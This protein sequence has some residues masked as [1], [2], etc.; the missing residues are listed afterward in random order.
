VRIF[1]LGATGSTPLCR[2]ANNE[3][4]TC[5]SFPLAESNNGAL[6]EKLER[7]QAQLEAQAKEIALLK[8]LVCAQNK[9]AAVCG[10]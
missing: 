2:N 7:Q 4:S 3:I 5:S 6:V 9:E 1:G 10:Q 8:Q